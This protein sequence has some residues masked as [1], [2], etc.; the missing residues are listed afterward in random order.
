MD[1]IA[2]LKKEI[3]MSRDIH[4]EFSVPVYRWDAEKQKYE[5]DGDVVITRD[6][7]VGDMI[8]IDFGGDIG[9]VYLNEWDFNSVAHALEHV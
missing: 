5:V 8:I 1:V 2:Q 9:E 7:D 6:R 4:A 3:Q